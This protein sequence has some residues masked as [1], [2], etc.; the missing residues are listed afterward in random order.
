[1]VKTKHR[2]MSVRPLVLGL[3]LKF[4]GFTLGEAIIGGM[5]TDKL[6]FFSLD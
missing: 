3:P 1:M 2:K 6:A 4:G 5:L